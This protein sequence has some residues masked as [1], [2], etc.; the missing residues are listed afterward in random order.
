[1]RWVGT[2]LFGLLLSGCTDADPSSRSAIELERTKDRV[3]RASGPEEKLAAARDACTEEGQAP[4][5][6]RHATCVI[7]LLRPE[8]PEMHG[9]I[10]SLTG[11]AA[12]RRYTCIDE[13]RLRLVRCYDI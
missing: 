4:G 8:S 2:A 5:T 10:E 6:L 13:L 11:H 9:L 3:A 12:K 7:R 1:M